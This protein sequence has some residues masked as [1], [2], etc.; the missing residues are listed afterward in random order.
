MVFPTENLVI[1]V[2]CCQ[3]FVQRSLWGSNQKLQNIPFLVV[4]IQS[5]V[6]QLI[7]QAL[8]LNMGWV[9]FENLARKCDFISPRKKEEKTAR[10]NKTP[11][12]GAR[13]GHDNFSCLQQFVSDQ[14]FIAQRFLNVPKCSLLLP[15][16][17]NCSHTCSKLFSQRLLS[18]HIFLIVPTK[19]YLLVMLIMHFTHLCTTLVLVKIIQSYFEESNSSI[20]FLTDSFSFGA[21]PTCS[22]VWPSRDLFSIA[23][24]LNLLHLKKGL[25]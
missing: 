21:P 4:K 3:K 24:V 5:P 18:N 20:E 16:F 23:C 19:V 6:V 7:T 13:F 1:A 14:H 9:K 17:P 12:G 11:G 22:T 10:A 8:S 15:H 2:V 25:L